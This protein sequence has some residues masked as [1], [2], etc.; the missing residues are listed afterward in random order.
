MLHIVLC[1]F[2]S[3][4][5]HFLLFSLSFSLSFV[6]P[7]FAISCQMV[8]S[9]HFH[10]YPHFISSYLQVYP[11]AACLPHTSLYIVCSR[12][13]VAWCLRRA[14]SALPSYSS[15]KRNPDPNFSNTQLFVFL[16]MTPWTVFDDNMFVCIDTLVVTTCVTMGKAVV[17]M[18]IT[19]S[20]ELTT[21]L[22]HTFKMIYTAHRVIDIR[23]WIPYVLPTLML[24]GTTDGHSFSLIISSLRL[25]FLSM[26]LPN[27]ITFIF[28]TL[29]STFYYLSRASNYCLFVHSRVVSSVNFKL[30][31]VLIQSSN[32]VHPVRTSRCVQN[33][34]CI[35]LATSRSIAS[36]LA[37]FQTIWVS[38]S[39][40][41]NRL[42]LFAQ[43]R[44][45]SY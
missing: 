10:L 44:L 36:F 16:S 32:C 8:R 11:V 25:T 39:C 23:I 18:N 6:T 20:L 2:L 19:L 1:I 21:M 12:L 41:D 28:C 15:S 9:G 31:S 33:K 27:T 29:S 13:F 22:F 5:F 43:I 38:V 4:L 26:P 45:Q 37:R 24:M 17:W 34:C 14:S 42:L 30:V 7:S 40:S 3:V 35:A